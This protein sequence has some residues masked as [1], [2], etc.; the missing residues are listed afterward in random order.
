MKSPSPSVTKTRRAAKKSNKAA[1][2][3]AQGFFKFAI[4]A[5]VIA[6][7][8]FKLSNGNPTQRVGK[9]FEMVRRGMAGGEKVGSF[10]AVFSNV[11]S[12]DQHNAYDGDVAESFYNLATDFY[13][14]GWGDSFHFGFRANW[15]PHSKAILNSQNFV[16]QKLIV[17]DMDRVLDMGCGIGG[18]LRGVVRATGAQVTGLTINQHQVDRAREITS[19]LSPWMQKRCKFERQD[20]LDVKGMEE[21]AYDA[22]FY[23]ESSLHCENRTKT[24]EQT[25]KLLKPGGRLVAMEYVLLDGWNPENKEHQELM[26]LHLHGNGCAKTPTIEEDLAMI[27]AAGF[28]IDEHFDFMAMGR[29][30]YGDDEFPWWGDL[31]FQGSMALLP[32]NPLVRGALAPILKFFSFLGLVP[33]DVA[34]AARLMNMGG[35]GLSGL[36]RINAITPQYY[37]RGIKPVV[38]ES[39]VSVADD[40]APSA[41]SESQE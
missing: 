8:A 37:V 3:S 22:A 6:L 16:A 34:E 26:R 31:Q 35:D 4:V 32:A 28:E 33:D 27:R 29:N 17:G 20:Y 11:S 7:A 18:P 12:N 39:E 40:E 15:E 19:K 13:E 5:V 9:L 30:L 1:A 14:Y 25:Y 2:G 36:G 10:D 24:F 23:M 41:A 38:A 21:G